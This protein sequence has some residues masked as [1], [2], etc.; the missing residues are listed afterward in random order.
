MELFYFDEK[1][2]IITRFAF[3]VSEEIRFQFVILWFL[4]SSHSSINVV[5]IFWS[6]FFQ[7]FTRVYISTG[8][9]ELAFNIL[10]GKLV[11]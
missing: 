3:V 1:N 2:S 6:I 4:F 10:F 7:N 11:K 9:L 5:S 8:I